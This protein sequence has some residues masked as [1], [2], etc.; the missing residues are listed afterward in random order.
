MQYAP[1]DP[2]NQCLAETPAL[3]TTAQ[4]A[5]PL[6]PRMVLTIRTPS[7]T[8]TVFLSGEDAK[9]WA[10]QITREAQNVSDT[11]LIAAPG[12]VRVP[13]AAPNG[14]KGRS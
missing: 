14:H 4:V 10:L 1:V 3:L 9:L 11:G 8:C 12:S 13:P 2:A 6:G 7:V 5:T